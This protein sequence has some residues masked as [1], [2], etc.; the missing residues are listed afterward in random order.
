MLE[1]LNLHG[2]NDQFLRISENTENKTL[3]ILWNLNSDMFSYD[4]K[5]FTFPRI[6]K[7]SI[8]SI[9]A[10]I[11]DLLGLLALIV[12]VAKILMQGLWQCK[13]DWYES[14][15]LYIHTEWTNFVP[16]LTHIASI[17]IPR[18]AFMH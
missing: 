14:V 2:C 9:I 5:Q 8:L 6:T 18:H 17:N 11:Y 16:N 3:G 13:L 1:S 10:Q 4:D 15:P 12:I 7:R